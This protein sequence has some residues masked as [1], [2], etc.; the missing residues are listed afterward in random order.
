MLKDKKG[1][2]GIIAAVVFVVVAIAAIIVYHE[3]IC[4]FLSGMKE[5]LPCCKKQFTPEECEDFADI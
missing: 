4:S 2:I 1:I 5:K 3:Q